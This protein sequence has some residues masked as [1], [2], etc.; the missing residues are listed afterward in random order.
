MVYC[1][2]CGKKN[3]DEAAKFCNGCGNELAT[4]KKDISKDSSMKRDH[5]KDWERECNEECG[6]RR[7]S[8]TWLWFWVAVL[9]LIVIGI[10]FGIVLKILQVSY[11]HVQ[12]PTWAN[13]FPYWEVCG[14]LVVLLFVIVI[15][16]TLLKILRKM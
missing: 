7:H 2:K 5:D 6:G 16:S 14:L 9:V 13:N 4:D 11:T 12:I 1:H 15:L 8:P 3:E 10:T